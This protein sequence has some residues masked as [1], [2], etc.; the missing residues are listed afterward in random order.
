M[1][2]K[3]NWHHVLNE[4]KSAMDYGYIAIYQI[5]EGNKESEIEVGGKTEQEAREYARDFFA[6]HFFGSHA[7]WPQEGELEEYRINDIWPNLSGFGLHYWL[8][9]NR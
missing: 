8:E 9:L 1:S 3:L 7:R 5:G 4:E 6:E 2:E